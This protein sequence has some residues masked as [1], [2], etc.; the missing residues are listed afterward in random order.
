MVSHNRPQK[1]AST[2]SYSSVAAKEQTK[3]IVTSQITEFKQEQEKLVS[4]TVVYE[5]QINQLETKNEIL[6]A[7]IAAL[8]I[9]QDKLSNSLNALSQNISNLTQ[10]LTT[11]ISKLTAIAPTVS[12]LQSNFDRLLHHLYPQS[13]P[14]MAPIPTQTTN[15][16]STPPHHHIQNQLKRQANTQQ[17]SPTLAPNGVTVPTVPMQKKQKLVVNASQPCG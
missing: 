2:F 11:E 14:P 16:Y 3:Q 15:P 6:E 9:S 5:N 17:F 13:Y 7:R 10:S 12:H 1:Q 4:R 8:E